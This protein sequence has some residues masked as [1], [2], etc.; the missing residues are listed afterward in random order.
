M[1]T[2]HH[3]TLKPLELDPDA[4][5]VV[6]E[7]L[8]FPVLIVYLAKALANALFALIFWLPTNDSMVMEIA[9]SIS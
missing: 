9:R 2:L 3:A 6:F 7:A 8:D 4:P 1:S 5:E